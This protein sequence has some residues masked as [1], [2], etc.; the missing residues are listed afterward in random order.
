MIDRFSE[1]LSTK[2]NP[3]RTF[4]MD[5]NDMGKILRLVECGSMVDD[6]GIGLAV[7]RLT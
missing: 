6:G 7:Q 2:Y 3:Y 5:K 1:K 4:Q